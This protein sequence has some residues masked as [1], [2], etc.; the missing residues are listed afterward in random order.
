MV[1][2]DPVMFIKD[3]C[4]LTAVKESTQFRTFFEL[5][6]AASDEESKEEELD[7]LDLQKPS[8]VKTKSMG[9]LRQFQQS[10]EG[11]KNRYGDLCD[12]E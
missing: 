12:S 1:I 5:E 9:L 11:K 7:L 4:L 2:Q 8:H 6:V 10:N 3:L